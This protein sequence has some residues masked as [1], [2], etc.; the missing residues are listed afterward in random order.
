MHR[1]LGL[2]RVWGVEYYN[3]VCVCD[4]PVPLKTANK[5]LKIHI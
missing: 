2:E 5:Q 4:R 3:Q 1:I